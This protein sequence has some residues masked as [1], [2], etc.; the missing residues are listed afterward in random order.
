MPM[1]SNNKAKCRAEQP[2]PESQNLHFNKLI[3]SAAAAGS[4]SLQ[5]GS[6]RILAAF[7]FSCLF[8][9]RHNNDKPETEQK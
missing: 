2:A 8:D 4:K 3:F 1:R 5:N 9:W 6:A 7:T